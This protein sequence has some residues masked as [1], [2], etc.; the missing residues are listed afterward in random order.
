MAVLVFLIGA[1]VGKLIAHHGYRG[2]KDVGEGMDAVGNHRRASD[3]KSYD[4]FR[5]G[6]GD[7]YNDGCNGSLLQIFVPC[8]VTMYVHNFPP[9][10]KPA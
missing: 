2:G 5:Q 7:I 4:D 1:F 3:R 8:P 9:I 10:K 6:H